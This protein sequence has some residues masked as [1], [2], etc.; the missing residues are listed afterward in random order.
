MRLYIEPHLGKKRLDKL[1][2]RDIRTWLNRLRETCQCCARGKDAW[3]SEKKRRCCVRGQC[4]RQVASDRTIRD[5]WTVLR[6]ALTNAVT[7]ELIAKNVAALV[8][9]SKGRKNKVKPWPVEEVR[10]FLESARNGGIRC[11]RRTC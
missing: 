9:V 7:E 8:R 1:T 5:A 4:C 3:R 10:R 6:S 11:M 2:V